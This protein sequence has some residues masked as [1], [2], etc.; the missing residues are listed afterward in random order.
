M[1]RLKTLLTRTPTNRH[2]RKIRNPVIAKVTKSTLAMDEGGLFL[3]MH[4]KAV[5]LKHARELGS[6]PHLQ[7]AK[8]YFDDQNVKKMTNPKTFVWCACKDFTFRCEV[9][10]AIRGSSVVVYSNGALPKSTNPNAVPQLCSH[11]LAFL[12]KCVLETKKASTVNETQQ[13]KLVGSDREL[14]EGLKRPT[15][16]HPNLKRMFKN[17]FASAGISSTRY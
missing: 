9:A 12:E 16:Q 15:G 14:I 10:L 2:Q 1:L 17:Y 5:D 6:K 11:C 7:V 3:L 13:P 8:L 4:G